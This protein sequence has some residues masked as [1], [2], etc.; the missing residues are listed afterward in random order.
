MI[1]TERRK[2]GRGDDAAIVTGL[3]VLQL[4]LLPPLQDNNRPMCLP[5]AESNCALSFSPRPPSSLRIAICHGHLA[6]VLLLRPLAPSSHDLF[7]LLSIA[8]FFAKKTQ[9][10]CHC[11][12]RRGSL[13]SRMKGF[14]SGTQESCDRTHK[15]L[16]SPDNL[17]AGHKMAKV[18]LKK[19]QLGCWLVRLF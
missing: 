16:M 10:Q 4:P 13:R 15:Y 12:L 6:Q 14:N 8:I 17:R 1:R 5:A 2:L 7:S 19:Q 9:I 18:W 3:S 11:S